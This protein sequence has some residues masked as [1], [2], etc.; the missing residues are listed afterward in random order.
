MKSTG[1]W[2][3]LLGGILIICIITIIALNQPS[4]EWALVYQDGVLLDNINPVNLSIPGSFKVEHNSGINLILVEQGRIR[5]SEANC[6]DGL[7]VRQGWIGKMAIPIVCL[8]HRLIIRLDGDNTLDI[9][10][11]TG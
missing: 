2:I 4:A 8:P 6:P 3:I 1:F 9:D 5:V 7:C 11:I 10:A